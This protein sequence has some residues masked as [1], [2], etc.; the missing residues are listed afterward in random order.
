[1]RT[2]LLAGIA[3][4]TLALPFAAHAQETGKGILDLPAGHTVLNVSATEREEVDQDTLVANLRYE[5]ENKD[6]KAL[7]NEI[8]TAMKK[9][10]DAAK[11]VEGVKVYTQQYYVYEYN[12]NPQ[13]IPE[14][15]KNEGYEKM[16]RGQQGIQLKSKSA[17]ELL[18]LT[19]KLQEMG[20]VME[21]LQYMLSPEKAQ[22]IQESLMEDALVKIKAKA[23]RAA[24]ALGK[25]EVEMLEINVD[26]G[27]YFPQPYA[28]NM[29]AMD[30]GMAKA[31]MAAPVAEPGQ[32]E[33][34]MTVTA[35][36]LLKP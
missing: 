14:H 11:A 15:Q 33:I 10:V 22:D 29:M 21:G 28:R 3:A 8:N 27:G 24:K 2:I 4:F 18:E 32:S 36:V 13:P 1:M 7:Q 19:G 30:A 9:A 31:E 25:K 23:E 5:A 12:P 35:R 17:D 34:N 6:A 16:W 20:L 26:N